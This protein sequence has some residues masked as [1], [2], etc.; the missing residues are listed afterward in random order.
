MICARN[1]PSHIVRMAGGGAPA[2]SPATPS[3]AYSSLASPSGGTWPGEV[4]GTRPRPVPF[5]FSSFLVNEGGCHV[6]TSHLGYPLGCPKFSSGR[7]GTEG[8]TA[9]PVAFIAFM[10]SKSG[11]R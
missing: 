6:E 4:R 1:F 10:W 2:A 8:G 9:A 3:A 7:A 11:E 5:Q